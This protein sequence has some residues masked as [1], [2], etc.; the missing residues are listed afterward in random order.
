MFGLLILARHRLLNNDAKEAQ[1]FADQALKVA[2][3]DRDVKH[4]IRE[5]AALA[6]LGSPEGLETIK[7]GFDTRMLQVL[8]KCFQE[9]ISCC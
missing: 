9:S 8:D 2:S 1:T 7:N 6:V 5:Y 4:Y 3:D